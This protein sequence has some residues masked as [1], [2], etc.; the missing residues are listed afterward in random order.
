LKAL[1]VGDTDLPSPVG[2]GFVNVPCMT[3]R[4]R[5]A[6]RFSRL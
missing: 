6:V 1:P 2:M 4:R 3:P 5:N